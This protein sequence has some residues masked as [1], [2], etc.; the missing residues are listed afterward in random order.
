MSKES[1]GTVPVEGGGEA[2][3]EDREED[4]VEGEALGEDR[5]TDR[6]EKFSGPQV[7]SSEGLITEP[8]SSPKPATSNVGDRV[9]MSSVGMD[10]VTEEEA[11][12]VSVVVD[13]EYDESVGEDLEDNGGGMMIIDDT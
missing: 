10:V 1:T 6:V 11:P 9:E 3:G 5:E 4:R 12:E 7:E 13:S 8:T 2:S